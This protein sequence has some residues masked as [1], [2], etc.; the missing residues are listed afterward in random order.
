V[1]VPPGDYLVDTTVTPDAT[2]PG[3]YT[4][5]IPDAW[6][7]FFT[8]GGVSMGVA[9]RA[10]EAALDRPDL[11]PVTASAT[12]CAAQ[13]TGPITLDTMV[14]R[15][16]RTAAQGACDT[17]VDGGGQR[18]GVARGAGDRSA[19]KRPRPGDDVSQRMHAT[20]GVDHRDSV[21][22]FSDARFPDVPMP[23]D[24]EPPPVEQ[25]GRTFPKLNFHDQTD[26]RPAR[27]QR[28]WDPAVRAVTAGP[29]EFASWTRLLKPPRHPDGSYDWSALCVPGD[30]VGGAFGR[31]VAA[32]TA[33][34]FF[35]LSLEISAHFVA[36]P[37][38][39]W[40]LQD[41]RGW[42]AA[43]GYGSGRTLLWDEERRLLATFHQVA[44]LRPVPQPT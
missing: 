6:K 24:C 17:L 44:H 41:A 31:A 34:D 33:D 7:I 4:A 19:G 39:D 36:R 1:S 2:V 21:F 28:T 5:D 37:A 16:G 14:L 30:M 3:R 42:I 23:D 9:L 40:V 18:G 25:P 38:G 12:F 11:R 35:V 10:I 13:P 27:P 15:N 29:A 26:F 8:F 22:T 32:H 20:F 43:D